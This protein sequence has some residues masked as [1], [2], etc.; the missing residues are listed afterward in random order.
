MKRIS[1]SSSLDAQLA[2]TQATLQLRVQSRE[3]ARIHRYLSRELKFADSVVNRQNEHMHSALQEV[4]SFDRM[5]FV[6]N[7]MAEVCEATGADVTL[8][9]D[10]I[11]VPPIDRASTWKRAA[12]SSSIRPVTERGSASRPSYG[13]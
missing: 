4:Y 6:S 9:A 10:A 7:A 11:G 2:L 5:V 3:L 13:P 8:L 12:A 1:L